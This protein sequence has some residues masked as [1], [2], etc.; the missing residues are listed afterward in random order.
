MQN[1]TYILY[2][3]QPSYFAAKVRSYFR[4]KRIPFEERLT[5]HPHYIDVVAPKAGL[6]LTPVVETPDGEVVQD[7]TEII[8][9][10]EAPFRVEIPG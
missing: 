7:T 10:F 3:N 2:G 9:F 6:N 5:N 8:D 4:K 1:Q